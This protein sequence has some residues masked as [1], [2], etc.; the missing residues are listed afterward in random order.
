MEMT[1]FITFFFVVDA[2]QFAAA[3][4]YNNQFRV[5]GEIR[6]ARQRGTV[7]AARLCWNQKNSNYIF[8]NFHRCGKVSSRVCLPVG[9]DFAAQLLKQFIL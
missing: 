3:R 5:L 6:V 7:R 4:L 8:I 2:A 1:F 9:K